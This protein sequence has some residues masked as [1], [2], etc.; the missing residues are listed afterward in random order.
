M[1]AMYETENGTFKKLHDAVNP[2][3]AKIKQPKAK[4]LVNAVYISASSSL[5]QLQG[6]YKSYYQGAEWPQ[7]NTNGNHTTCAKIFLACLPLIFGNLGRLYWKCKQDK[8]HGGWKHMQLDGKGKGTDEGKDLKNFMDLMSFSAHWLNGGKKGEDVES[9]MKTSFNE[10]SIA[11]DGSGQSYADFLKKFKTTGIEKWKGSPAADNHFLSGLYLCS[12]SY[13]RHQ[14]QKNAAQ[15][16]PPSSIRE[17]LYW[18]MGLTVTPQFDSL[19]DH[20]STVVPADFKVAISGSSKKDETLKPDDLAGHFITASLSSSWILGTIQGPGSA[21]NPLLHEIYCSVDLSYPS[22]PSA[23]LSKLADYAYALQFQLHFLYQQCSNTYTKACG[24]NECTYGQGVNTNDSNGKIVSSHICPVGCTTSGHKN[25]DHASGYC[26]HTGC[27]ENTNAS[28]LQAFLTDKLRGFSR[29]HPSS[30]SRHLSDCSG[31]TCHV[32]MDFESH[33]RADDKYQ[34]SH[35]SVTLRPFCGGFNTPLRQLSEKLGCLTKRTP[36]T[37]GDLFGFTWHLNGQLFNSNGSATVD[38]LLAKF[39]KTLGLTKSSWREISKL[40]PSSVLKE[41]QQKIAAIIS[42]SQTQSTQSGIEKSLTV[43]SGLPFL[44]QLFMVTPEESLPARLFKLNETDHHDRRNPIN[45]DDLW[46]LQNPQCTDQSCG[47]YLS[48]L[49]YSTGTTFDPRHASSYLSWVLY[50]SD[51]LE[52]GFQEM[53]D[54]FTNI[55]CSKTGCQSCNGNHRSGTSSC[56]CPS[57]VQCGGT[58]PLLYRHGFRYNNPLALKDGWYNDGSSWKKQDSY[59]RKCSHLASQLNN[60]LQTNSPLDNL[61]TTIDT[62]LYA[63]RWEFFSKLSGFWTIYVCI[64]LYTFFLLLDTLRVRYHLH[65]PSSNS[66]A[67]ISLLGTG[68]VPALKKFTKLTYFIP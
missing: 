29:G 54:E 28:P 67:P 65:F 23:L 41:V 17:M 36:R 63:I 11:S 57:V 62:F 51:D 35:I 34:G 43:F 50:L 24:W 31:Y 8:A 2:N 60:L 19:L 47:K 12:T 5:S 52:A 48:P 58:L 38:L 10:F 9:V 55:D 21:D 64:I 32:P 68:K 16:R 42:S 39:F 1:D 14:H 7:L 49:C 20:F 27:G 25:S 15:A 44:Y 13:F 45:H 37:L 56:S 33:L 66:I 4:A 18:L 30:H 6:G 40:N 22:S 59:I 3:S 26:E 61:L 53:L 46:S